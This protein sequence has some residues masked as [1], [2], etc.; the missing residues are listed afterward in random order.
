[1]AE[2]NDSHRST[3][4]FHSLSGDPDPF[5]SHF[6]PAIPR[7]Q[8][9]QWLNLLLFLLTFVFT[10]FI[11]TQY[12]IAFHSIL[13]PKD[14]GLLRLIGRRPALL[15]W[16]LPYSL[17]L[18]FI[19]LAHELGHLFACHVHRIQATLPF[20][21]PAPTPIGTLGAFIR[22][23]TRFTSKK[24]LFDVGFA[25]PV[26]GFA[27]A[28][29]VIVIGITQS[30][31]VLKNSSP[32]LISLGEPLLFSLITRLVKG[33]SAGSYDILLHPIAFAGWFGLLA[34]ALNLFP[35]GQLDGGHILYA[36]FGRRSQYVGIAAV[37]S[38]LALGIF[39]WQGWLLLALIVTLLGFRH[40]AIPEG[41]RIDRARM[42]WACLALAIFVLSFT[43][44][45]IHLSR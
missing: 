35:I 3:A 21:I 36:L 6:Q 39:F 15:L 32:A 1:M 45:P 44:A 14:V 27:A 34:T 33:P 28:L 37:V 29:P 31:M 18:L 2:T 17:S 9:I 25:G 5:I 38:L 22:I 26:C 40:P 16:G 42:V 12:H 20:F 11:G 8:K 7:G 13:L 23:R 43:P 19:L 30:K 41:E 10:L 4:P 24:S